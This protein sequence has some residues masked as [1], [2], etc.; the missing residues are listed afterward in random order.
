MLA[1]LAAGLMAAA[2]ACATVPG[3]QSLFADRAKRIVWVGETHG[4]AQQPAL[5]TDIVCAAARTRRPVTVAL[6]R[7]RSEQPAWDRFLSSDGGA[8]ARADLLKSDGWRVKLQDGRSSVAMLA[9]AERLRRDKAA[10]LIEGVQLIID[11]GKD[12]KTND[13][14]EANMAQLVQAAATAAPSALVLVYSGSAHAQKAKATFG[15]PTYREAAAHLPAASL[16][17]VELFGDPGMTWECA[18]KTCG[19]QVYTP[20]YAHHPRGL[21]AADAASG[22]DALIYTGRATT[23]SPPAALPPTPEPLGPI[24]PP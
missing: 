17:S 16:V 22:Y 5:F 3:V 2:P 14:Y 7:V 11:D 6:E 21:S 24:G 4:T 10:G 18:D 8:A 20:A 19:P 12:F 9:L 15:G 1:I 23:A 13:A